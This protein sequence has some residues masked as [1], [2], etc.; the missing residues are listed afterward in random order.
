[1]TDDKGLR[2]ALAERL[3]A[4]GQLRSGPWRAAVE[5]VP[6]HEFLRGGFF[7]RADST[8]SDRLAARLSR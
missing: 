6:R 4:G 2:L 3:A 7:G 5:A 8:G 1:M